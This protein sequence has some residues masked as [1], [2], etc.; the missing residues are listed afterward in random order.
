MRWQRRTSDTSHGHTS[1][2]SI[3]T[4]RH[5]RVARDV[6]DLSVLPLTLN[7]LVTVHLLAGERAAATSLVAEIQAIEGRPGSRWRRTARWRWRPGA[8]MRPPPR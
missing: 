7:S 3:L 2:W 1:S 8:A 6:G 4:A 5:V